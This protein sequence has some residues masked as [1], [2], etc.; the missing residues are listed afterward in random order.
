MRVG[1]PPKY[2]WRELQVGESFYV[3]R[4]PKKFP[5]MMHERARCLGVVFKQ[6]REGDGR[7]VWRVA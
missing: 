4:P 7:R 6:R 5:Q 2:P 3:E 1:R